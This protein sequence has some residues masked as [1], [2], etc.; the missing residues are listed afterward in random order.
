M[1]QK[2]QFFCGHRTAP[3]VLA[4]GFSV[5]VNLSNIAIDMSIQGRHPVL[6]LPASRA[7]AHGG[8]GGGVASRQTKMNSMKFKKEWKDCIDCMAAS[9]CCT[10][11]LPTHK[12][13][14][15][16]RPHQK[17]RLAQR[18]SDSCGKHPVNSDQLWASCWN[19]LKM[20]ENYWDLFKT[21]LKHCTPEGI[22]LHASPSPTWRGTP[23]P[24]QKKEWLKFGYK[25]HVSG[26]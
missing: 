1:S 20:T 6:L 18:D 15:P 19:W 8:G 10:L 24:E 13:A 23:A 21:L 7:S 12:D 4:S 9:D 26:R 14:V 5:L 25:E 16:T 11:K 17:T 2:S 22:P 3:A